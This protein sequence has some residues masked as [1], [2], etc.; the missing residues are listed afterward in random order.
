MVLRKG[1]RG[2]DVKQLQIKLSTLGYYIDI[3][4]SFGN[5][6]KVVVKSF[7]A[8][9]K[10]K[11]DGIYGPNTQRAIK[12]AP[13]M[14]YQEFWL[15]RQIQVVKMRKPRLT[16]DLI[17]VGKMSVR[18]LWKYLKVKPTLLINGGLFDTRTGTDLNV[19]Y[20]EYK[21]KGVGYYSK[22]GLKIDYNGRI[23]F[24]PHDASD[25]DFLGGSPA[26]ILNSKR[27]NKDQYYHLDNGFINSK[28]PR[29]GVGG[30]DSYTYIVIYNGRNKWRGWYGASLEQFTQVF[31]DLGCTDAINLDGGGSIAAVTRFG[32][33][34]KIG[35]RKVANMI[36]FYLS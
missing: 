30:N 15:S 12:V 26:L 28:H 19:M 31:D 5:K 8:D 1:K 13:R 4:S 18:D 29:V 22:E 24:G 25:R 23:S 3:D 10:L 16:A 2:N 11:I 21:R 7:Q 9:N 36:A 27:V 32:R 33:Y 35:Y 6:T 14:K 17:D 20:D 34:F